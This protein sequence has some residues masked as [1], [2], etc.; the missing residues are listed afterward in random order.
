MRVVIVGNRNG[1]AVVRWPQ[2]LGLSFFFAMVFG[3]GSSVA[4]FL[5][6]HRWSPKIVLFGI[7]FGAAIVSLGLIQ[8]LL[9][10]P[11]RLTAID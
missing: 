1:K 9:T 2:Y 11:E 8:G 5:T 10:P 3:F 4:M 6:T 7:G